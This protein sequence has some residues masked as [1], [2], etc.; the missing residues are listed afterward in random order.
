MQLHFPEQP[1]EYTKAEQKILEYI[2][3]H[4][5]AFLFMPI[6]QLAAQLEVSDATIS[7]FTR[8]VGC[9]DFKEL[10]NVVMQQSAGEGP[11]AKMAG[12]LFR[13]S[14]FTLE[15]W[16]QQQQTYLQKTLE[17]LDAA[18]FDRAVQAVASAKRIFIHA[19][20]ASAGL[21]QM[22]LFRLRRMGLCVF[23]IPSGGS[24]VLE[25]LAQAG[26]RD[27]VIMFMFSKV[28]REAK[29]ILDYQRESGCR[30]LAFTSRLYAPRNE[31]ADINLY[32]Y[33]GDTREYHSMA[34]PVALL[35]ALVVALSENMGAESAE[36]LSRLHD[37]KDR[38]R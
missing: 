6:G 25:G 3:S 34:A 19:K 32:V 24:E 38:Y 5:E 21:G 4:T 16:L 23:L 17:Q 26:A 30:T 35:D 12:T 33:R 9:R 22:L 10:K 2:S 20:S 18:E 14:G 29:M 37:L 31:R 13:Q 27:I 11:A 28:S 8:H 36:R 7:R 1:E 15:H